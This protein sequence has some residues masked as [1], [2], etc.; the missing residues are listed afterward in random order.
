MAAGPRLIRGIDRAVGEHGSLHP[1]VHALPDAAAQL[2]EGIEE[3]PLPPAALLGSGRGQ[4]AHGGDRRH[5]RVADQLGTTTEPAGVVTEPARVTVERTLLRG[6][7][8]P[9]VDHVPGD[10]RLRHTR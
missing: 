7:Q 5:D 9:L 6:R 10:P 2:D 1:V 4:R 8:T 3:D